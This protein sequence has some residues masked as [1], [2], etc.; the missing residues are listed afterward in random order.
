[1]IKVKEMRF[2]KTIQMCIFEGNPNGRI[3]CE[4]SNWNGRVY[5][6]SRN[7]LNEFAN[8][9]DAEFTGVYFLF[10]KD[11]DNNDTVYIGEAE[12]MLIR[13]KQHLKD[14]NY[15]ND[16]VVVISKD[17]VLNKAHVKFLENNFYNL[18]NDA[19][20]STLINSNVP[21]CS[22]I[23]EFDESMLE[24]FI[25]NAK[26]LVNTLGY[27]V[28]DK[29][30][31]SVIERDVDRQN[32]FFIKATRGAD[33]KGLLVSDGLIVAKGSKVATDT[34]PSMPISLIDLRNKLIHKG[35]IDQ[36]YKFV[37]DYLFTSPSLAASVVMG[38]SANGR[39]E[40]K[41]INNV[42]IKELEENNF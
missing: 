26:L 17:N 19:K 29:I 20:R 25:E 35:I 39:T 34:V 40:W 11:E 6:I 7:D 42:S 3:M 12:R 32:I 14:T 4:L 18:A 27:K 5:K 41:N 16:C 2:N 36:D 10:G 23:S 15:W 31:L 28:F 38:R 1:M 37:S 30:D 13:L 8:R 22:S 33:A 21:T 9:P 24:E